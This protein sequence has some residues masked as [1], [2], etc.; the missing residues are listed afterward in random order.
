MATGG[1]RGT[2][3]GDSKEGYPRMNTTAKCSGA[4]APTRYS[5]SL[6][7]VVTP[8][9]TNLPLSRDAADRRLHR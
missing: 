8:G 9:P 1:V 4:F 7:V 5:A 3:D 6:R 2:W